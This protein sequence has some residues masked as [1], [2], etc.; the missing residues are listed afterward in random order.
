MNR[1]TILSLI[2]LISFAIIAGG[3]VEKVQSAL[4]QIVIVFIIAIPILI[5]IAKK[6]VA[7]DNRR[8]EENEK[9]FKKNLPSN[10]SQY[11]N[12]TG[13]LRLYYDNESEK[14]AIVY[15]ANTPKIHTYQG[16]YCTRGTSFA[17]V[18]VVFDDKN[19]YVY[20]AWSDDNRDFGHNW[21]QFSYENIISVSVE[22][23]GKTEFSKSTTRTIGGALIGQTIMGGTGAIIGGLTG[24]SI[25]NKLIKSIA[26]KLLIRDVK[27][28]SFT[29]TIFDSVK[30][31]NADNLKEELKYAER[32][33]DS[34][35]V[36]IDKMDKRR[37]E[38]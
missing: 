30:S 9:Q 35:A 3:S 23:D 36:I 27:S 4:I 31:Q 29:I 15:L 33:K 28:P 26:V 37:I 17:G 12:I 18:A 21:I 14:I 19:S 1:K 7:R 13:K 11:L 34:F 24:S 6:Q 5:W 8:S 25:E 10:F 16:A 2:V 22:I 32:L 38:N 20:I